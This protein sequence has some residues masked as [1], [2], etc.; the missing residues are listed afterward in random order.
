[1]KTAFPL[2]RSIVVAA[3]IIGITAA[4]AWLA[5][6]HVSP[7]LAKR[8]L[9]ALLG[10]VV[11]GYANAIPK[12]FPARA[13][14]RCPPAADQAARRFA[15]WAMMLGGLGYMLTWLVAPLDVASLIG[16][17]VLGAALLLAVLRCVRT[18]DHGAR[19]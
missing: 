7:E 14:Q 6:A 17:G 16:G 18:G 15:G 19:N 1:M 10:A 9:G 5:P 13:L 8:A 3:L 4:L 2:G 11:A 12:V